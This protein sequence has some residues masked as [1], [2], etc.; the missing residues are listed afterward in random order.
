MI[1]SSAAR[2][3]VSV[4]RRFV[5]SNSR[6]FSSATPMLA[7]SVLSS[8]SSASLKACAWMLSRPTTPT[9]RSP[10]HDRDAEPRQRV[11]PADLDGP[12]GLLLL[13]RPDPQRASPSG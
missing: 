4:S 7:A 11:C 10:A 5:S 2:W 6:A 13:D 12:G 3:S 9:T 1:A 8:R